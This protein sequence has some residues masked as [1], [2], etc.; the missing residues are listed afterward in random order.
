MFDLIIRGGDVGR[1]W[2]ACL[3]LAVAL[4]TETQPSA[5]FG[6]LGQT[7]GAELRKAHAEIAQTESGIA[8]GIEFGEQPSRGAVGREQLDH[9]P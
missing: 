8:V 4:D 9:G 7:D 5:I 3:E 6:K 1:D 2:P